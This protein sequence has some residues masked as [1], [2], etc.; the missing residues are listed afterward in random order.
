L[1]RA[2]SGGPSSVERGADLRDQ[3]VEIRSREP[4]RGL[5]AA[6]SQLGRQRRD[7]RHHPAVAQGRLDRLDVTPKLAPLAILQLGRS[8]H[9]GEEEGKAIAAAREGQAESDHGVT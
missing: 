7:G 5:E 1:R 4:P 2:G 3:A 8:G 6:E 9:E